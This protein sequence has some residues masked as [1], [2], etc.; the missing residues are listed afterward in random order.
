[1]QLH[2]FLVVV[3]VSDISDVKVTSSTA[4]RKYGV[5]YDI[6]VN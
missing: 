1:M 4:V 3:V 6:A 5:C 2:Y